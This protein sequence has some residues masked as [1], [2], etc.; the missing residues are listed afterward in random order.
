MLDSFPEDKITSD[1]FLSVAR[2]SLLTAIV[3]FLGYER[4]PTDQD[5]KGFVIC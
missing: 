1:I 3:F 2:Q 5:T 4:K